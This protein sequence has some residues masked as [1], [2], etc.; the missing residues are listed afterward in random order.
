MLEKIEASTKHS[1][2][3]VVMSGKRRDRDCWCDFY[4]ISF[5][6]DGAGREGV[7]V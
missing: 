7:K 2:L 6:N 1:V 5:N 4:G 3:V